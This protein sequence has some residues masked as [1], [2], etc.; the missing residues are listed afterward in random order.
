MYSIKNRQ[1]T[2]NSRDGRYCLLIVAVLVIVWIAASTWMQYV[3]AR[4][5]AERIKERISVEAHL[6][7]AGMERFKEKFGQYPPNFDDDEAVMRFVKSAFP[8]YVE[9]VSSLPPKKLDAAR[10]LVFWLS[11]LGA[12][13][14]DPFAWNPKERL[15]FF[16]F[17]SH[18][19]E[20]NRFYSEYNYDEGP[21]VYFHHASYNSVNYDGLRPYRHGSSDQPGEYFASSS[22]QIIGSGED[23]KLGRGGWIAELSEDDRDNVTSFSTLRMG[24]IDP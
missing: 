18:Q 7:H 6:L 20:F 21:Y 3:M 19:I 8:K 23:G 22:I 1:R 5:S 16:D 9:G 15:V 11:D 14:A 13:P 10:A 12:D 2:H 17:P 24:D 4:R